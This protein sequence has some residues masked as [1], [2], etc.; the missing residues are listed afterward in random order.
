M[1]KPKKENWPKRTDEDHN[2]ETY[3]RRRHATPAGM[4][5]TQWCQQFTPRGEK[6]SVI[7]YLRRIVHDPVRSHLVADLPTPKI[8]LNQIRHAP[9]GRIMMHMIDAGPIM[10]FFDYVGW[11]MDERM[12]HLKDI[13]FHH[14][15]NEERKGRYGISMS[16]KA[17]FAALMDALGVKEQQYTLNLRGFSFY[18]SNVVTSLRGLPW[19]VLVTGHHVGN[20]IA[21]TNGQLGAIKTPHGY[22]AQDAEK[23]TYKFK[24]QYYKA[25]AYLEMT[26]DG[27]GELRAMADPKA[28]VERGLHSRQVWPEVWG[29]RED[30]K[31]DDE[32]GRNVKYMKPCLIEVDKTTTPGTIIQEYLAKLDTDTYPPVEF[33][34]KLKGYDP[35]KIGPAR[36]QKS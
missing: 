35:S 17:I 13:G 34:C 21:C 8:R 9:K 29:E 19:A 14:D 32:T 7:E 31:M 28:M 26:M 24:Y 33:L 30:N 25:V 23:A 22:T 16:K 36:E 10:E 3:L 20:N 5:D 1:P 6:E 2:I 11:F 15:Q 27:D 18:H 4:T 12:K